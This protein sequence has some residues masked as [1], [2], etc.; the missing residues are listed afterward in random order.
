MAS[1]PSNVSKFI[2]FALYWNEGL[3]W[4]N[5]SLHFWFYWNKKGNAFWKNLSHDSKFSATFAK[6]LWQIP[7][8]P[9]LISSEIIEENVT[10]CQLYICPCLELHKDQMQPYPNK[11]L[12]LSLLLNLKCTSSMRY[13]SRVIGKKRHQR[14][15]SKEN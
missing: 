2:D 15:K 11:L 3:F 6:L 14:Q 13:I 8:I 10:V 9:V 4:P 1:L 5:L 12:L 7:L